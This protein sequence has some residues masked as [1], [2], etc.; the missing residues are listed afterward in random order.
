MSAFFIGEQRFI[1]FLAMTD[2]DNFDFAFRVE[3]FL[4]CLRQYANGSV[5]SFLHKD[6]AGNAMVK[7]KK[8]KVYGFI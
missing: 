6:I 8:H 3:E 1:H 7:C 5:R 2:T 4:D